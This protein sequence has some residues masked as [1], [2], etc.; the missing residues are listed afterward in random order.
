MLPLLT[1]KEKTVD[2]L[3]F[4]ITALSLILFSY[5][6]NT[7]LPL[8]LIFLTIGQLSIV[9]ALLPHNWWEITRVFG[10]VATKKMTAWILICMAGATVAAVFYRISLPDNPFPSVFRFFALV[11]VL[12]GAGEEFVFRGF[13]FA[14]LDRFNPFFRMFLCTLS[15]TFYK[16]AL[17][18]AF[19]DIPSGRVFVYTFIIG[20]FLAYSRTAS[21]SI[22]PCLTFHCLFDLLAY[23]ENA[24]APWWVW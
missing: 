17:F 12:I 16:V 15:H 2:L 3:Q 11:S 14:K 4:S 20:F 7:N 9:I 10:I 23:G 6:S 1:A 19:D 22:F 18:A 21:K 24:G 13:L 5:F 8:A